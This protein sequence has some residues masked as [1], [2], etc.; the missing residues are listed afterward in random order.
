M[1]SKMILQVHDELDF[2]V[3]AS[4]KEAMQSLVMEEMQN[5]VELDVPLIADFG[6]GS[7]WLQA[8]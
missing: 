2:S 1:Q 4:E 7:N 5:A 8:H 3:P 6:W